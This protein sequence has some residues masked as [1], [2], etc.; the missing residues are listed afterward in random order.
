M[1]K[2]SGDARADLI[3]IYRYGV[4]EFGLAQAESYMAQM[5]SMLQLLERHPQIAALRSEYRPPVRIHLWRQHYCVYRE[6]G[7]HLMVFRL[8]HRASDLTQH[9]K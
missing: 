4:A 2:Y 8:L 3:A 6:E 5:Q 9:L 7:S 1:I